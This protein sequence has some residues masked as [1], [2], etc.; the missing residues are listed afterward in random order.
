M[1]FA[2]I[3]DA[4]ISTSVI[5][6]APNIVARPGAVTG[7]S[8]PPANR[9]VVVVGAGVDDEIA[10]VVVGP[11]IRRL[12]V[13]AKCELQ[14]GHARKPE[15]ITQRFDLRCD[16]AKVLGDEGQRCTVERVL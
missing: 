8:G 14:D 5:A 10:R 15:L 13:G 3:V 4:Q 11:E 7:T 6:L 2:V 12:R 16:Y 1:H 9:C